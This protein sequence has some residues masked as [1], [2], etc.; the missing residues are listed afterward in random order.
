MIHHL[1]QILL[2]RHQLKIQRLPQH[3]PKLSWWVGTTTVAGMFLPQTEKDISGP[4]VMI[5]G[6]LSRP[7]WLA[8]NLDL[9]MVE[10]QLLKA[11]LEM[12]T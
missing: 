9:F 12:L 8:I 11:V 1:H 6:D 7:M 5:P 4:S 3:N 2:L 10:L